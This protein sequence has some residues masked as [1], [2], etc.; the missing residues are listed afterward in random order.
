[1]H[2]YIPREKEKKLHDT[3]SRSPAVA[4]PGPRQSGKSTAKKD[5]QRYTISLS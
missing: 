2:G 1:M 4:I 5:T 3:L